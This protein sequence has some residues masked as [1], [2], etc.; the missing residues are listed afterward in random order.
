MST[1]KKRTRRKPAPKPKTPAEDAAQQ[2]VDGILVRLIPVEGGD[3]Q[4]TATAM[5][6]TR[7]T[8]APTILRMAAKNVETQLGID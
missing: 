1:G 4:I 7:L 8:E 3:R 5:G 2:P 6:D